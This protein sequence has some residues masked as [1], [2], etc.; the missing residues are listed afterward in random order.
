MFIFFLMMRVKKNSCIAKKGISIITPKRYCVPPPLPIGERQQEYVYQLK[1]PDTSLILGVGPAGTGKTFF[2]CLTAIQQLKEGVFKKII[3]TRPTVSVEGE[4]IGY[5]PGGLNDKM[6]P[7]TRPIIDTFSEY[8]TKSEIKK[9]KEEG[10][11]EINPLGFMRGRTFK[12]AFIVADE[13]QNSSP[14]QMLML[15]T[16][17]GENSKIVI[18]GDVNQSDLQGASNGLIDLISRIENED[19]NGEIKLIEFLHKDVKRSSIVSKVLN[20]YK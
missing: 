7:W 5:L 12:N 19:E 10:I 9:M 17:V 8:Y 6:D 11:I 14:K 16:R 18:N 2:A 1:N 4:D 20:L 3:I 15:L 13:M